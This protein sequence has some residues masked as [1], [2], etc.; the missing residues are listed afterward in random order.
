MERQRRRL[1]AGPVML[2]ALVLTGLLL[3]IWQPI[4]LQ[5][6][7]AFGQEAAGHP[8]AILAV[9]LLMVLMF[10][11]ALPGSACLWLVAPFHPPIMATAIMVVGSVV[12]ALG[13]YQVARRLGPDRAASRRGQRVMQ[14]LADRSDLATQ[15]ALRIFPGFPHAV[16]NYASGVLHLPLAGFLTAAIVGLTIKWA[17]YAAAI[18]NGMG[19]VQRGEGIDAIDVFPLFV[20][21]ALLLAGNWVRWYLERRQGR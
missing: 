1:H 7:L 2:C 5:R 13:A 3:A 6:L 17:V 11:F 16:V 21:A 12:G 8:L 15:C 19:A 14:I 9:I 18:H 20:L 10:T 4:G